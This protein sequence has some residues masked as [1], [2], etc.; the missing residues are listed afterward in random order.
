MTHALSLAAGWTDERAALAKKLW[1]VDG[2]SASQIAKALG[3]GISRNGVIGKLSRMG[4]VGGGAG[5][6]KPASDLGVKR[7]AAAPTPRRTYAPRIAAALKIASR[8]TVF[9]EAEACPARVVIPF[10]NELPGSATVLTIGRNQCRWPI[11]DPQDDGFT[12]CGAHA[13]GTYCAEHHPRAHQAIPAN[14][15]QTGNELQRSL[16]R[17]L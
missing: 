5:A 14:R 11:G 16:R 10:R 12:F 13:D 17:Y 4:L 7:V 6:R 9:E 3:G 1:T 2:Y 8:G 15:P